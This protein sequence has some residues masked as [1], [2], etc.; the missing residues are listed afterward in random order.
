MLAHDMHKHSLMIF[1]SRDVSKIENVAQSLV[2]TVEVECGV[3][4]SNFCST[5]ECLQ[6]RI[7]SLKGSLYCCSVVSSDIYS[8]SSILS[9]INSRNS[10]IKLFLSYFRGKYGRVCK[11]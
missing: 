1:S 6:I 11:S 2:H 3:Q 4:F 7:A 10:N 9:T 5:G 8:L